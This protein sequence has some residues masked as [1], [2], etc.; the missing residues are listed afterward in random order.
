[1]QKIFDTASLKVR[2]TVGIATA[3]AIG[4]GSLAVWTSM[5]MQQIL[6]ST[7]KDNMKYIAQRFPMDVEIYSEMI[8]LV[9]GAQRA[10][11]S[12][13]TPDKLIWI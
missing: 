4:L 13:S 8:P 6:V 9:D 2:L 7:H 12:L 5:R 11:D 10:I 1:M 3:T